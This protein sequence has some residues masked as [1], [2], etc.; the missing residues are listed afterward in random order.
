MA[1]VGRNAVD[2]RFVAFCAEARRHGAT[3]VRVVRADAFV[4]WKMDAN[5]ALDGVYQAPL[6]YDPCLLLPGARSVLVL[7]FACPPFDVRDTP[8]AR[9]Y[10]VSQR[11]Y[12]AAHV[13][14]D[15]LQQMGVSALHGVRL[16]HRAAAIRSGGTIGDNGLYYHRTWGSYVHIELIVNDAFAPDDDGDVHQCAHCGRCKTACPTGALQDTRRTMKHCLRNH[17]YQKDMPLHMRAHVNQLLGCERCQRVCSLNEGIDS[18]PVTDFERD[19]MS[20]ERLLSGPLG[21]TRNLIGKN[22]ARRNHMARQAT[23]YIGAQKLS[24]CGA[25]LQEFRRT[26]R[27]NA[28]IDWAL[29]RIIDESDRI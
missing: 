12:F 22:L 8:F 24:D 17:L 18:V 21:P 4:K 11:G 6:C 23:L 20:L 29:E 10:T 26:G 16:P 19:A 14:V 3:D 5:R 27:D 2:D 9:Y 25:M 7:F 15:T 1:T 28:Y 13:L